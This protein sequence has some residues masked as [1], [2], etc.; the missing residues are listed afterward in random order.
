MTSSESMTSEIMS[1]K[2]MTSDRTSSTVATKVTTG[3]TPGS[4]DTAHTD[5]TTHGTMSSVKGSTTAQV[6]VTSQKTAT[7]SGSTTL[8]DGE[9]TSSPERN[10]SMSTPAGSSSEGI[11]EDQKVVVIVSATALGVVTILAIIIG[12]ISCHHTRQG[13]TDKAIYETNGGTTKNEHAYDNNGV[14]LVN[15]HL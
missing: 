5:A 7:E 1:S 4:T 12:L 14:V 10:V 6:I 13:T 3:S 8:V 15:T 11:S 2:I 9:M